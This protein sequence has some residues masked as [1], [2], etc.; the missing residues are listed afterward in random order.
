MNK[1]FKLVAAFTLLLSVNV[2]Y[3]QNQRPNI[4]W[5]M[6]EDVSLDTESYGMKGVKTPN[7]NAL[8]EEGTQYYNC[9]GTASICSTNRSSM[10]IGTHQLK[11]NTM[12]HRS[13]REVDLID[14]YKPFT[15]WLKKAGYTTIL[16]HNKVKQKGRKT[17]FNF[18]YKP[19]GDWDKDKGVFDRFGVAENDGQPFFQQITLHVTHRG[20]WWDKVRKQ[21][22]HPVD[23]ASVELP[24]YYADDPRIRLDWAK[25]LDQMEYADD[26]IGMLVQEL[27]DKGL[28]ENT[29]III[30]GDNGRCNV[31]GKGYLFDPALR[32]PLIVKWPAGFE[33]KTNT[34]A[35]ISSTDI[36]AT[37]LD[38][39]GVDIPDYM[40]GQSFIAD[41]FDREEVFSYRG[42]WDEIM[43]SSY[44]ISNEKY[45]YIRN[46]HPEI[47]YDAKQAYLEFYR[48]AVHVMRALKAEGKLDEFQSAFFE[49]KPQEELY[50]LENDPMEKNNLVNDPK[51]KKVLKSMR[52]QVASYKKAM[53]S[54]SDVYEPV[55]A[56]AVEVLQ[57]VK[58][59][60]PEEYQK[61]LDGEEIGFYKYV[62]EYKKSM[63]K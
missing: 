44:A 63:M 1:I 48:P 33:K 10:I 16:G 29:A 23:P 55:I 15:Y 30:I 18:N 25:Y 22:K 46:D 52:K 47:P 7:M 9:F 51:Y 34:N 36:T 17:D 35:I 58:D 41:D 62:Q 54:D 50:D 42:L 3:A 57:M 19:V 14:P 20:D 37:I 28:Y 8:A 4:I 43:E 53:K 2:G 56:N 49:T 38:I 6:L 32:I 24:P 21:S 13:N 39:A 59:K 12:H 45:R 26:E 11:T 61:M 40:T 60:H 31:R 5:V 27:K